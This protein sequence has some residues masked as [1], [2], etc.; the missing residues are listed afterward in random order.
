MKK[1]FIDCGT[2]FGQGIR[3]FRK[4]YKMDDSWEIFTWEANPY[5]YKKFLNSDLYKNV[6]ITSFNSA[7]SS[8]EGVITLNVETVK[9][10]NEDVEDNTGQ[11]SSIIPI[12]QWTAVN[13]KHKGVFLEKLEIPCIDISQW[14]KENC[15]FD[16]FVVIKLDVEGA[17][18]NILEK[19]LKDTTAS[20]IDDIYIEWHN[21]FFSDQN[22][23]I[24]KE[25]EIINQ[26][27][28]FNVKVDHWV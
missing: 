26:L 25:K 19:I 5:T 20:L 15:S 1:I 11:G 8:Y 21:R 18:Y 14:L 10:K 16:D 12:D 3:A 17:E 24:E 9:N 7:V 23:Y 2:H 27:T 6:K 28:T 4:K 22:Y 13:Q